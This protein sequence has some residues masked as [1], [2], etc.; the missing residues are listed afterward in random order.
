MEPIEGFSRLTADEKLSRLM[1]DGLIGREDL[2][3]IRSFRHHDPEVFAFFEKMTE[4]VVAGYHL[5]YSI[6]PNFLIN[7]RTYHVPM[8]TEESSVVAAASWSAKF[9]RSKGGFKTQVIDEVKIGQIHFTWGGSYNQLFD[10]MPLLI[11][12]LSAKIRPLTER[13]ESRGGG[14]AGIEL[15]DFTDKA[16]GLYQLRASFRTADAMGANFI[17]TCLEAM[18]E[19]LKQELA[20][21]FPGISEPEIIM[22]ILSNYTPDCLVTCTVECP[23]EEL[24]EIRGAGSGKDF[25]RRFALAVRIAQLD[26]YRAVTHNKGIY[27][28]IDSVVL[29][30]ANDFRAVEAGGHAFASR[31]GQYTSLTHMESDDHIFRYVLSVPMAVGTVGG[32]TSAHPLARL[33]LKILGNPTAAELMQIAAAAGMANNFS[34]IKALT[35][36]GIQEGHMR[37]HKR[38]SH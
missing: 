7:G 19:I 26:P 11:S 12:T 32:L 33:S 8:V 18:S 17:N 21:R 5:P 35:T 1:A 24:A 10:Y 25:A 14:L 23:I 30:T 9:W 2:E 16:D 20:G 38:K 4:N 37:L 28:G 34:A 22:S 27:N 31:T 29:S 15:L 3:L 13:M 36:K 6:A